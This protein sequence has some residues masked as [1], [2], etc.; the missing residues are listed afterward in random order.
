MLFSSSIPDKLFEHPNVSAFTGVLDALQDFKSGIIADALRVDNFALLM[1]KKW[2]LKKLEEFGIT[3]VP[4]DYPIQIIQQYLLNVDTICGT[5]GSKIG[6]ELYCSLLSLGEVEVDD[7]NFYKEPTLLLLDSPLQGYITDD[8]SY[9]SFFLCED[10]S[11]IEPL[12][13]MTITIRSKYF[14]GNYPNEAQLIK[15]YLESS[16]SRQ[17]GFSPNREITFNYEESEDFYYHK[18]LNTYFAYE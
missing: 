10:N 4:L 12:K 3:D 6:I 2:L 9:N 15:S 16:I 8:N 14:N 11:L 5:R 1:D 18:L 13:S 7:S 17:L